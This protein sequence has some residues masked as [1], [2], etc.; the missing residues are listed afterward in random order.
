MKTLNFDSSEFE[1]QEPNG[2]LIQE[3]SNATF[4]ME[5]E[6][7]RQYQQN[8]PASF[9]YF[10]FWSEVVELS[11][12]KTFLLAPTKIAVAIVISALVLLLLAWSINA[13]REYNQGQEAAVLAKPRQFQQK[14]SHVLHV[15]FQLI[16]M[17]RTGAMHYQF[18]VLG[19]PDLIDKAREEKENISFTLTFLDTD[20][21]KVS[22]ESVGLRTMTRKV[23]ADGKGKALHAQGEI[24]V[25]S[26]D[27]RRIA[28]WQVSW[29][30]LNAAQFPSE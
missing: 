4:A 16:G 22:S 8:Y 14:Q 28:G 7:D 15:G 20:G 11:K 9:P 26:D 19:Y 3:I 24:I 6:I 25:S 29:R 5:D 1:Q 17:W 12:V 13:A 2:E 27:Y 18:A 21:F 10:R 30:G 23:G